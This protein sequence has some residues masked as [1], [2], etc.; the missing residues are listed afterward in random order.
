MEEAA[1]DLP[2]LPITGSN[3]T[4]LCQRAIQTRGRTVSLPAPDVLI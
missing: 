2:E 1:I 4:A 3:E